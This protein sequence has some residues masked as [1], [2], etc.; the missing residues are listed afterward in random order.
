MYQTETL[1]QFANISN[2]APEPA[3]LDLQ[4]RV[5]LAGELNKIRRRSTSMYCIIENHTNLFF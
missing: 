2:L 3:N 4:S 1:L 5:V